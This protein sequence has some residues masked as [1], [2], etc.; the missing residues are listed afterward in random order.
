MGFKRSGPPKCTRSLGKHQKCGLS[1]A[2]TSCVP[3]AK[4]IDQNSCCGATHAKRAWS[5]TLFKERRGRSN[6]SGGHD[7]RSPA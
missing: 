1:D 7:G 2:R 4:S 3:G 6:T 5:D